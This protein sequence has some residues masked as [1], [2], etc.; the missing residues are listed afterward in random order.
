ML[1][2][3]DSAIH[4]SFTEPELLDCPQYT[5]PAEFRGWRVPD[6]LM[7]G[8]HKE[9]RQWR[10]QAAKAKTVRLRPDLLPRQLSFE[11]SE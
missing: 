6:V 1:G 11:D 5:R 4:E 10:A 9:I 3:V 7:G 8:N 2:N